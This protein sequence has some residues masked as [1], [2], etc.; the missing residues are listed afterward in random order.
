MQP[1]PGLG[2]VSEGQ[3]ARTQPLDLHPGR[4]QLPS[5]LTARAPPPGV[6]EHCGLAELGLGEW[7]N[8][9]IRG[10]YREAEG[11]ERDASGRILVR[12]RLLWHWVNRSTGKALGSPLDVQCAG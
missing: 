2:L 10:I 6:S 8:R 7:G 5:W 4:A 12:L 3:E 11:G 9:K 1:H